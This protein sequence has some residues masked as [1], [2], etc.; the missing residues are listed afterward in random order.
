MR[1]RGEEKKGGR[2]KRKEGKRGEENTFN[3]KN[4]GGCAP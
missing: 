4:S 1:G 3:T 2:E